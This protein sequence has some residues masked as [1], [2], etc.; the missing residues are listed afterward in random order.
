MSEPTGVEDKITWQALKGSQ[1][2]FMSCPYREI[3]YQGSRGGGKTDC[4][5]M[6]FA[7]KVG[8]GY[9]PFWTGVIFR[10]S[11]K[12]LDDIIAKSLRWFTQIFPDAHFYRG[13]GDYKWVFATGEVLSFRVMVHKDDYWNYHGM[14]YPFIAWEELTTWPDI[15][16][17]EAMFSCNRTSYTPDNP[18]ITHPNPPARLIPQVRSSTNPYG[19]GHSWVKEYFIDRKPNGIPYHDKKKDRTRVHIAS[20]MFENPYLNVE[21]ISD[22]KGLDDKNLRLAWLFGSWDIV[23][24]GMFSHV[25]NPS[26]HV[27]DDFKIPHTWIINRSFDWGSSRPF[28]TLWYAQS[29]GSDYIDNDGNSHATNRGDVFVIC[30]DYGWNGS[31][32]QGLRLTNKEIAK[33]VLAMESDNPLFKKHRVHA[34]PADSAIYTVENGHSIADDMKA[35]G[36]SWRRADKSAGSRVAG[37]QVVI[38]MLKNATNKEDEGLYFFSSCEH[39]QRLIPVTPR[40]DKNMDDID[41]DFEDHLQDTLRYRLRK[42]KNKG[43][44]RQLA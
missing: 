26:T 14:E 7:Q 15:S 37:W 8:I 32:N 21:Y 34:G 18:V 12:E 10:R 44:V 11:Y 22:M 23:A 6:S 39:S 17:Y 1:S 36:V 2:L 40:D 28:C 31:P 5:L 30:E 27:V 33:R 13:K 43:K 4:I 3:L 16:C 25:W 29:D 20:T 19:V 9:G 24:G 38:Q 42:K 41:T 35:V